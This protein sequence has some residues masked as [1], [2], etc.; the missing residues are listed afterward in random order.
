MFRAAADSLS[1]LQTRKDTAGADWVCVMKLGLRF[2][3]AQI[4]KKEHEVRELRHR[5][6]NRRGC[7]TD[8][9]RHEETPDFALRV[10]L[11]QGSD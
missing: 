4:I 3:R 8:E 7:S 6:R 2:D 10:D 1:D 11:E 9:G 5:K